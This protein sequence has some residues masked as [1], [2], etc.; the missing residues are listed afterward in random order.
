MITK[1][2]NFILSMQFT[3]SPHFFNLNKIN[4]YS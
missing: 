2:L 4:A 3:D 1:L